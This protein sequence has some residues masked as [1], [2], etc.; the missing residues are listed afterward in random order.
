MKKQEI[1]ELI[2]MEDWR[3]KDN[4]RIGINYV[5]FKRLEQMNYHLVDFFDAYKWVSK[6]AKD[7]KISKLESSIQFKT[8]IKKGELYGDFKNRS[9]KCTIKK[10]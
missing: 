5:N 7:N 3:I 9:K 1:T 6:N 8:K 2:K 10:D 4:I